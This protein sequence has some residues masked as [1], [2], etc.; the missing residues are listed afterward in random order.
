VVVGVLETLKIKNKEIARV[1][2][3]N[4]LTFSGYKLVKINSFFAGA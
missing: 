4:K 3:R 1:V 2:I